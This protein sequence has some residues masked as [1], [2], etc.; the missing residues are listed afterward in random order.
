LQILVHQ[1][2]KILSVIGIYLESIDPLLVIDVVKKLKPKTSS[3]H[4]KI[5]TKLVKESIVNITQPLTNIINLSLNAGIVP[6]QLKIAKVRAVYK[7]N[8]LK[9]D[10]P[11]GLMPAFSK[12]PE[13]IMFNKLMSLFYSQKIL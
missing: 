11:I 12:I 1:Q 4:D 10:R 3:V 6:D 5:S 8:Q 9:H 2:A 7:S 13:K